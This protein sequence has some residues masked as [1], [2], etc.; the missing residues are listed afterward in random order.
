[1]AYPWGYAY[2]RLK[3]TASEEGG[4]FIIFPHKKV[5][6]SY[7]DMAALRQVISHPRRQ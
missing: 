1:L 6:A 5:E 3:T 2:N 4:L 7:P